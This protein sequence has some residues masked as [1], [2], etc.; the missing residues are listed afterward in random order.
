MKMSK[1]E[2]DALIDEILDEEVE[3]SD[4]EEFINHFFNREEAEKLILEMDG[5]DIQDEFREAIKKNPM[6]IDNMNESLDGRT[7]GEIEEEV[8]D[9]MVDEQTQEVAKEEDLSKEQEEEIK[10]QAKDEDLTRD[11]IK[12]LAVKAV[13]EQTLDEYNRLREDLYTGYN[14]QVKTGDLTNGDKMDTKLV[15][16]QRYIRKLDMQYK[17]YTGHLITQDDEEIKDKENK[18]FKREQRNEKAVYEIAEENLDRVHQL[19]EEL[20]A[21]AEEMNRISANS[22]LMNPEDFR[23]SMEELQK[24]Y[25]EKTLELRALDPNVVELTR[26]VE[27]KEKT[28]EV[29]ERLVGQGYEDMKYRKGVIDSTNASLDDVTDGQEERIEEKVNVESTDFNLETVSSIEEQQRKAEAAFAR[30]ESTENIEDYNEAMV[31][32]R[33]AQQMAGVTSQTIEEETFSDTQVETNGETDSRVNDEIEEN[34]RRDEKARDNMGLGRTAD[35]RISDLKANFNSQNR[36]LTERLDEMRSNQKDL[37]ENVMV[38]K[39]N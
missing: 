29:R 21:I 34:E 27:A 10:E 20:N 24:Q 28:D 30:F 14:G 3:F 39:M 38:R 13:Y 15:M 1:E 33:N 22:S 19:N 26:Q 5:K 9:E 8:R 31:Y 36:D 25:V 4:N 12:A 7:R 23:R 11:E 32:L 18:Y 2:M 16:Y 6:V 35:D 17:G 37:D